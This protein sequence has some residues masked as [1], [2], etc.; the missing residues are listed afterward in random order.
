MTLSAQLRNVDLTLECERCG[1][2]IVKKGVWFVCVSTFKC[3]EC[4]SELRL[5]YSDKVALFAKHAAAMDEGV[6]L[7]VARDTREALQHDQRRVAPMKRGRV[8]NGAPAASGRLET[9]RHRRSLHP[10]SRRR[11]HQQV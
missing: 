6:F 1:H 4:K 3:V 11:P 9:P 7:A 5:T 10:K 8:G 2:L